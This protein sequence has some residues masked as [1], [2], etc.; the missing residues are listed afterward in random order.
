MN[1]A[2]TIIVIAII[3]VGV[4]FLIKSVCKPIKPLTAIL[5][6][7]PTVATCGIALFIFKFFRSSFDFSSYSGNKKYTSS[8]TSMP[9]DDIKTFDNKEKPKKKKPT[10]SFTDALGK[11][12]YYDEEG[13]NIGSSFE[14]G[15]GKT[16]YY[17]E[18]GNYAGE[19]YD[20]GLGH[21]TY[22][23]KDGN[24]TSSNTNYRGDKTFTDGT[25]TI[26]DSS[27][28]TYYQ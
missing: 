12:T 4:Y 15:L 17:D 10:R 9:Y 1:T 14:H 6:V 7:V 25:T 19:S 23:D 24:I 13:K 28:N 16:T 8:N 5:L 2:I 26:S 21:T 20:N 18:E 22:T 11:T 3:S 27:G